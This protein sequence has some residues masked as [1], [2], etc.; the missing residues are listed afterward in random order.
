MSRGYIQH[1]FQVVFRRPCFASLA[2]GL[3]CAQLS[4][5]F[6]V[7]LLVPAAGHA[8]EDIHLFESSRHVCGCGV[9]VVVEA[10]ASALILICGVR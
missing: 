1:G 7:H 6:V 3:G 9:V 8:F 10:R 5:W 4:D 2:D